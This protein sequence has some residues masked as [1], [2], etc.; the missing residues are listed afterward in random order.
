MFAYLEALY[1]QDAAVELGGSHLRIKTIAL[2]SK[3]QIA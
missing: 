2:E 3:A 1:R